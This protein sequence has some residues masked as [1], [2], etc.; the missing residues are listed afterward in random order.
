VSLSLGVANWQVGVSATDL[1]ER[2]DRALY[3]A[4]NG[5]RDCVRLFTD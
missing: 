2:A 4:K 5:G 1:M 3:E